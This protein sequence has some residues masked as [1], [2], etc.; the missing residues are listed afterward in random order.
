MEQKQ[1]CSDRGIVYIHGLIPRCPAWAA[2]HLAHTLRRA[3]LSRLFRHGRWSGTTVARTLEHWPMLR[4]TV[5]NNML[6][7]L[8]SGIV[9]E[10]F[11]SCCQ[12]SS[13]PRSRK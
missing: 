12:L 7:L 3:S 8:R 6:L 2:R 5:A 4:T 11:C 13:G 1:G 9:R 10:K